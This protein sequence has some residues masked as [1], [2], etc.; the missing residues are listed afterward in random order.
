MTPDTMVM[1]ILSENDDEVSVD[2]DDVIKVTKIK[3]DRLNRKLAQV[4]FR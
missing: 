4:C 1:S 2:R 3:V